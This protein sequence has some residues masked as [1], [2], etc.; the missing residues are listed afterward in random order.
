MNEFNSIS[1]DFFTN[2]NNITYYDEPH[3]YYFHN[4]K[5]FISVTTLIHKYQ[6]PF[7]QEYWSNYIAD[8]Y[9]IHQFLVKRAWDFI[10]KKGTTL[11][12]VIHDYAEN[13]I[14]NKIFEYP[15]KNIKNE[16]G[17]DPIET[18][19]GISKSHVD[20]FLNTS[21][22][23]LIP[24]KT[25][26]VVYDV[27]TMIAGMVDLLVYN[28]KEKEY[29]IW[30]YKTNKKFSNENNTD[31]NLLGMLSTLG[32]CDLEI[33]SLQLEAYKYI[34]EKNTSIKLGKSY[35][36]WVSHNNDNFKIIQTKDRRY[37]IEH[38]F[39]ERLKSLS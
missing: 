26:L 2:F 24:I 12:S 25:E 23:K 9:N 14:L 32:D 3:E 17:F 18:E 13:K 1:P 15:E 38:I 33:Y 6:Q 10:N 21:R 35:L 5:E 37:F 4:N 39:N 29:Q 27:E 16:F 7:D 28:V 20:N 22:N 34:I 19:Y 8:K 11:G 30:D 31:T 36:V